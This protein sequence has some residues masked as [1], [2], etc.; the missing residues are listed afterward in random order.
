MDYFANVDSKTEVR[1]LLMKHVTNQLQN[2]HNY[3]LFEI[4]QVDKMIKS[5]I[6]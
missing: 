6:W 3:L 2:Q 4:K 1:K 5:N